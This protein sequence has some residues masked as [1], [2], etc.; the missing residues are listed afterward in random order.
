[1]VK[2]STSQNQRDH[3]SLYQKG[4]PF[5]CSGR[6]NRRVLKRTL[7]KKNNKDKKNKAWFANQR[8]QHNQQEKDVITAL[9][10]K[11]ERALAAVATSVAMACLALE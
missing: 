5:D 6:R 11:D 10:N 1:M 8:K 4:T 2:F 9:R 7:F 3:T